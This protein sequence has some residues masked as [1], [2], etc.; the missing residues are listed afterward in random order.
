DKE[1]YNIMQKVGLSKREIKSTIN[2]QVL[3]VFFM[4]LAF[5]IVNIAFAFPSITRLLEALNFTNA[6][7]YAAYTGVTCLVFALCYG[8]VYLV[9][10]K[11]Y[12]KIVE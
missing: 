12:Y 11:I 6:K 1:R 7:L 4:P 10:A 5:A 2:S 9:T 3:T 8:A